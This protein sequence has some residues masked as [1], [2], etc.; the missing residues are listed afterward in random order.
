MRTSAS[1]VSRSRTEELA[2][3]ALAAGVLAAWRLSQLLYGEDGPW[4]VVLRLRRAAGAT[5]FGALLDCFA[6]LSVWCAAPF[7]CLLGN[8]WKARLVLW[9]AL[10]GGA[11]LLQRVMSPEQPAPPAA[12]VEESEDHS[13]E[14]L[15]EGPDAASSGR[16]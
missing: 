6:C 9:P 16:E 10:S 15:R 8:N 14:L 12:Y 3:P 7:A 5:P 4:D 13:D 1:S 2:A 11:L